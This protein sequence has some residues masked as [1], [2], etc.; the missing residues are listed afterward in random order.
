MAV[1]WPQK[2]NP[3]NTF[4]SQSRPSR[5]SYADSKSKNSYFRSSSFFKAKAENVTNK[6]VDRV[7]RSSENFRSNVNSRNV[8]RHSSQV[9]K[10]KKRQSTVPSSSSFKSRPSWEPPQ[11]KLQ[12]RIKRSRFAFRAN[13]RRP[14]V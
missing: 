11:P 5:S 7:G 3:R 14:Q 2:I 8:I 6:V 12:N 13:V 4:H 9:K 10:I 1:S